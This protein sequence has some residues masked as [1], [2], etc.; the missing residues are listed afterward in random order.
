M[1]YLSINMKNNPENR[2]AVPDLDNLNIRKAIAYAIDREALAKVLND[3]SVGAE[4]II[5]LDLASNP[6]TGKDFREDAGA[7][8]VFDKDKAKEFYAAGVAELGHDVS[9]ELMYGSDEGESV[10]KAAE[11]IQYA[12]EEVGFTVTLNPKPKKERLALARNDNNYDVTLTRWG[13]DYGDPQTYMDLF[14][15]TNAS[16]NT[17]GWNNPEYDA[18]IYDAENG[19]GI[20]DPLKRW[21]NFVAAEKILVAD[22]AAV[23]PIFQAGGAI[24]INP[25]ISGIEFHSASVDNY[26]HIVVKR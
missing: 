8:T 18:L 21:E 17:G 22:D 16:Y 2:P 15:S 1:F 9:F 19:A 25:E 3:G 5:P 7:V 13:P 4:G 20:S 12:L 26:R 14:V 6:N 24:I 11:Q 10:I 23:V